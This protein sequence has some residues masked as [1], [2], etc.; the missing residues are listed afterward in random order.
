MTKLSHIV[1]PVG[2]L[3]SS[4]DWYVEKL[5]FTLEDERGDIVRI[6]DAGGLTIFLQ[7]AGGGLASAKVALT[8][9][10]ENVD[11]SFQ[12]LKGAG[13][14]FVNPPRVLFWGYGAEVLD[15]D[16]YMNRLWDRESMNKDTER[17]VRET[18]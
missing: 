13:V 3:Q 1:I 10:V 16:G 14:Q 9:E 18:R 4:R 17:R 8:I 12:E 5:G 2:D 7:E 11:K 15:P 6:R